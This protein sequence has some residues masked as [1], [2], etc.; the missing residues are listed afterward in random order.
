MPGIKPQDMGRI[1]NEHRFGELLPE[2]DIVDSKDHMYMS[3]YRASFFLCVCEAPSIGIAC[4][5]STMARADLIWYR[6]V[7]DA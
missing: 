3:R 7:M 6:N 1:M 5:S 4:T 2:S